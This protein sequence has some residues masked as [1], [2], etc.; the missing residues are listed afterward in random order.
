MRKLKIDLSGKV[1]IVTGA[2]RGI[3]KGIAQMLVESHARVGLPISMVGLLK[4]SQGRLSLSRWASRL[5]LRRGHDRR[6]FGVL[7]R[8]GHSGNQRGD[9][10]EPDGRGYAGGRLAAGH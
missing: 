3:G 7:E 9:C 1:L 10:D 8:G 2:A 5:V 6:L 4:V